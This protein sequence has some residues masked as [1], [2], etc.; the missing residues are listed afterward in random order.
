[1]RFKKTDL[2]LARVTIYGYSMTK[3]EKLLKKA[4]ENPDGLRFSE[5]ETLDE[6]I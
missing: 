3:S 6:A 1:V 4:H 2:E 5:F